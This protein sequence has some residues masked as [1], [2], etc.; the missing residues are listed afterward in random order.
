MLPDHQPGAPTIS[1]G[2]ARTV[3]VIIPTKNRVADLVLTVQ[4]LFQQ[5]VLPAELV[6]VDQSGSDES[7]LKVESLYR[8]LPDAQRLGL[9][10]CYVHDP[11]IHGSAAA[12]NVAID[13]CSSDILLFL[14]DDVELE[15]DFLDQLLTTYDLHP[16]ASGVSGI[17]TNYHAPALPM[18]LWKRIFMRGP[19]RDDRE[20]F[21]WKAAA[22]GD[23]GLGCVTRLGGGLMSFRASAIGQ[24]RFDHNLRGVSDGEDVDFCMHLGPK[25]KLI[26]NPRARLVHNA[27]PAGRTTDHWLRRYLRGQIYLYRR[28]W[29]RGVTNRLCLFWFLT[30][31]GL[32]ATGS[33]VFK[34]SI[35]AWRSLLLGYKD[36]LAAAGESRKAGSSKRPL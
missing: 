26:M 24:V 2:S 27:S 32:V 9:R 5:T 1:L 20:L 8:A 33:A 19:F 28:N 34:C 18:Q 30:G 21:Y 7:R 14:D 6:I 13:Q 16:N 23:P 4:T 29:N 35:H 31:A 25:A 17:V 11:D 10:L 3:S 22:V 12:R 36:G 15:R